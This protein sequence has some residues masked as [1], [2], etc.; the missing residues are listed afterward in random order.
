MLIR[1]WL[2][3][4]T[5]MSL[6]NLFESVTSGTSLASRILKCILHCSYSY[7]DEQNL[8]WLG[9]L[10]TFVIMASYSFFIFYRL[11]CKSVNIIICIPKIAPLGVGVNLFRSIY[12]TVHISWVCVRGSWSV[13][14]IETSELRAGCGKFPGK[15]RIIMEK[16]SWTGL[17]A[18][19][20]VT[21]IS[22][23]NLLGN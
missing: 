22:F 3:L 15:V 2:K 12:E 16:M 9:G 23:I 8:Q 21:K 17:A 11:Y 4:C 1:Q 7:K 6:R 19:M 20:E 10:Y 5:H 13:C 14:F 18:W